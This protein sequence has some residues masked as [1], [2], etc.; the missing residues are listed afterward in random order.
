VLSVAPESPAEKGGILPAD[1]L[2]RIGEHTISHADDVEGAL[3][4]F[5]PDAVVELVVERDGQ[6][7]SLSVTLAR[8]R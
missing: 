6:E 1:R 8:A 3:S 5:R 4:K 7:I 2:V